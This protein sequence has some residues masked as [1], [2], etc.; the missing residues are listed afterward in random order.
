MGLLFSSQKKERIIAIFD[1]GSGSVGGALVSIPSDKKGVPV[2]LKSVKNNDIKISKEFD[3]SSLMKD[4]TSALYLTAN[5]LYAEKSGAPD[6]IF[7]VLASPWYLS[8][9]RIVK[10]S[11]EKSFIFSKRLANDLIQKEIISLKEIFKNKYNH[12]EGLPEIIEQNTM[13]VSLNGYRIEHPLGKKCKSVEIDML[14]SLAPK[15]YLDKIRETISRT[16]H[17]IDINFASFTM[18]TYLAVRDKY[19]KQDSYLLLDISGEITDVGI[20]SKGILKAV[21]SFPFGKKTFFKQICFKMDIEMRD[22]V[23]LFKLYNDENLSD[24]S[25]IKM[26]PVF[27]SIEKSWNDSFIDCISSLP[28]TLVLPDTIFLT[29]DNDIKN[30]FA[31]ILSNEKYLLPTVSDR[32]CTVITLDGPEF[33]NM[34]NIK[35]GGCNPFLMIEAIAIMRKMGK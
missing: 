25:I 1:I 8:E 6:E 7:C 18:A 21:L 32:K 26:E 16:Y 2:I 4:M 31:G 30:W 5:S 10:L 24:E 9:T 34:C 29:A 12:L 17:N 27:K 14:I 13:A 28:R 15:L 20:V 23:E 35:E 3:F 19:V 33:L 22:A 11:K